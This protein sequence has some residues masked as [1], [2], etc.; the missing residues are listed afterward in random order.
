MRDVASLVAEVDALLEYERKLVRYGSEDDLVSG[1]G[2]VT[3]HG[4]AL[5]VEGKGRDMKDVFRWVAVGWRRLVVGWDGG[6]GV[7][8]ETVVGAVGVWIEWQAAA[9]AMSRAGGGVEGGIKVGLGKAG[10]K[11]SCC[12]RRALP[13]SSAPPAPPA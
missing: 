3:I 10:L 5:D 7:Y 11:S 13:L 9:E 8:V 1:L 12:S 4:G 6:W 2:L